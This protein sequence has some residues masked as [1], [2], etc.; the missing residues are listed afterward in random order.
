MCKYRKF[1]KEISIFNPMPHT[2]LILLLAFPLFIACEEKPK[3]Q[4]ALGANKDSVAVVDSLPEKSG[5]NVF[6]DPRD[7]QKFL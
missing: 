3:T 5:E 2:L 4:A 6:T 1:C 7:G